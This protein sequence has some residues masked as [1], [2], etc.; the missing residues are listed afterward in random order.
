MRA[1]HYIVLF[2]EKG[3]RVRSVRFKALEEARKFRDSVQYAELYEPYDAGGV[4]KYRLI[5]D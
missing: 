5:Q 2:E 4:R 1:S 3:G